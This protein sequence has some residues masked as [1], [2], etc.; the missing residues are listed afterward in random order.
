MSIAVTAKSP[1]AVNPSK[2]FH[3]TRVSPLTF[4]RTRRQVFV[5][6]KMMHS[7]IVTSSHNRREYGDPNIAPS[8]AGWRSRAQCRK[9][10]LR[11]FPRRVARTHER[12][13]ALTIRLLERQRIGSP[14]QLKTVAKLVISQLP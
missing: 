9:G 10:R 5:T 13:A 3:P 1:K 8:R 2:A 4:A 7:S 6:F 14:A 11:L 12:A